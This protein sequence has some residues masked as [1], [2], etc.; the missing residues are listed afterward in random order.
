MTSSDLT[1]SLVVFLVALPLCLGISVA[2]G[3]APLSGLIAGIVGG[4]VV[5]GLSGSRIG[6]SGPAAGLAVIVAEAIG[7][8]GGLEGGGF[9]IFLAAVVLA[10]LLQILAG[11]LKAGAIA[12][13]FPN[14]VI[15]GMLAGIGIIIFVKQIPHA[16]GDDFEPEGDLSF[17]QVDGETTNSEV[18]RALDFFN[19]AAVIITIVGLALIILSQQNFYK[20]IP[21]LGQV[22]GALL[23]VL[24]G[25]GLYFAFL[26]GAWEITSS[27]LVAMPVVSNLREASE[28]L[29]FPAWD[30]FLRKD[31][32]FTAGTL[33]MVA[34][35]ETLLCVEATDKL[36][37]RRDVTNT[38]RELLAQGAGNII[39]GLFGGLPI[40]QVV[41]RSSANL[42][43][44]ADSRWSTILHGG[45]LVVAVVLLASV[46][47]YIPMAA[48]AAVLMVVGYKLASPDLFVRQWKKGW[49]QFLPFIITIV[50]I[51]FTDLLKGIG[52]GFAV[53]TVFLLWRNYQTPY[54]VQDATSKA[55]GPLVL[56]L[57]EHVSFLN[58]AR[59]RQ[60]LSEI[61]AGGSVVVDGR[62]SV[63]I[64]QD[65]LDV[66]EDF[67]IHAGESNIQY[68]YLPPTATLETV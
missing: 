48:L 28:L 12:F 24:A 26:G 30:A 3:A 8:F 19:P 20:R 50:A 61:P 62:R 64:D 66:L 51:Y 2:S 49:S 35:I 22:P 59:I 13:F 41:V 65:V 36:D 15:K 27:H 17:E 1:A 40:T 56:E 32:W 9:P 58:K 45:W 23:A 25:V 33:A 44:G 37:P 7:R 67:R 42:Q 39:S 29:V 60:T 55:G 38:N 57:S 53:S 68:T 18:I 10:G 5:G 31:V 46:L 21:V 16:L 6:V 52:I 14:A 63:S 11:V 34:S 54:F 43:A 47:N 4:L